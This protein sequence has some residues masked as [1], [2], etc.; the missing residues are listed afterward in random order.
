MNVFGNIKMKFSLKMK[1]SLKMK[2]S[3]N[4]KNIKRIAFFL[5]RYILHGQVFF[6]KERN[7][8]LTE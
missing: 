4:I 8:Q 7:T 6:K 1:V 3:L 2:F 5:S